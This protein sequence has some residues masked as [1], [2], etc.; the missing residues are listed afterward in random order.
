MKELILAQLEAIA[1]NT[2]NFI[3]AI[4]FTNYAETYSQLNDEEANK[5]K[6]WYINEIIK[7][8][9]KQYLFSTA[10]PLSG[11]W[12]ILINFYSQKLANKCVYNSRV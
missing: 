12:R 1:D 4:R 3:D 5:V 2:R 6:D 7:F 8:L 11:G 9:Q 10:L